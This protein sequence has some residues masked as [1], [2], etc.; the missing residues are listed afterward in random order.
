[1]LKTIKRSV[2]TCLSKIGY[3][4]VIAKKGLIK[5]KVC[6]QRLWG[7]NLY[8]DIQ[9]LAK[10]SHCELKTIFIVGCFE[11]SGAEEFARYFPDSRIYCF[12]PVSTS[13]EKML[14]R[15]K[16]FKNVSVYKLAFG[17]KTGK[18][19]INLNESM[20]TNSLLPT[21]DTSEYKEIM[22]THSIELVDMI[23]MD[24]F[25]KVN[26]IKNVDYLHCDVQG[27]ELNLLLGSSKLLQE[28]SI[29]ICLL[30][31][32]FDPFYKGQATFTELYDL[33]INNNYRL[34]FLQGLFFDEKP[35]PRS[36]NMIFVSNRKPSVQYT[37]LFN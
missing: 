34:S 3:E 13:Y 8:S 23:T 27:Y 25:C 6:K 35:Y 18:I 16:K 24:E 11:G 9:E 19:Q 1:M 31:V 28:N 15:M 30:E 33:M 29:N 36:G 17:E 10:L 21:D 22:S 37:G 2:K 7:A 12:E 26:G 4:I 14:L 32:C 5:Y 20:S